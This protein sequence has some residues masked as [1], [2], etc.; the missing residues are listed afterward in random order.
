MGYAPNCREC[1]ALLGI[2]NSENAAA[3]VALVNGVK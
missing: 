2:R 1:S 3:Q